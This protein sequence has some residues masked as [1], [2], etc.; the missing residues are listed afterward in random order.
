MFVKLSLLNKRFI[1]DFCSLHIDLSEYLCMFVNVY[2]Y[3]KGI[4]NVVWVVV[5][6]EL[7]TF[8]IFI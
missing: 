8:I 6:Q 1:R 5:G 4:W 2:V 3:G 7:F